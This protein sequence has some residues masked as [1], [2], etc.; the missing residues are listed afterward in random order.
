MPLFHKKE[1]KKSLPDFSRLP[2]LPKLPSY[3]PEI[4]IP[5]INEIKSAI[6]P[7]IPVRKPQPMRIMEKQPEKMVFEEKP[8]FV[9][10]D[11]YKE[12][13]Q[14]IDGIRAKLKEAEIILEE[15]TKIKDKED[16]EFNSWRADI[17]DIKQKLLDVDKNLFEV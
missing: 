13:I 7:E 10:I 9:K 14:T 3:E 5:E 15:L 6:T 17:N 1:I 16:Q 8:L 2:E 11:K 4:K 12:A